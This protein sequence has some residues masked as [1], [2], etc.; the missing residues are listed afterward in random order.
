MDFLDALKSKYPFRIRSWPSGSYLYV[1]DE[2]LKDE[3][4][5]PADMT[6]DCYLADD[7][8]VCYWTA[9]AK[10]KAVPKKEQ[11]PC[12]CGGAAIKSTHA[13]WC[14]SRKA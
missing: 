9:P 11:E 6:I 3:N 12:D 7:W 13:L 8:E 10:P 5:L 2:V 4:D 1:D 14:S